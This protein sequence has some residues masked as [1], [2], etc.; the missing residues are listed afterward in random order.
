M[1]TISGCTDA[2]STRKKKTLENVK[3]KITRLIL[4]FDMGK[5]SIRK[6]DI[7]L[8]IPEIVRDLDLFQVNKYDRVSC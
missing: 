5:P 3:L 1:T 2:N 4:N 8:K 6:S 7:N